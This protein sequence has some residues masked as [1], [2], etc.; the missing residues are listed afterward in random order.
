M[1]PVS[2]R[3][4]IGVV[5]S[6]GEE[7]G[8]GGGATPGAKEIPTMRSTL[9]RGFRCLAAALLFGAAFALPAKALNQLPEGFVSGVFGH[10]DVGYEPDDGPLQIVT[11]ERLDPSP[12]TQSQFVVSVATEAGLSSAA[13]VVGHVGRGFAHL[14]ALAIARQQGEGSSDADVYAAAAFSDTLTIS[15]PGLA[16]TRGTVRLGVDVEGGLSA[17]DSVLPNQPVSAYAFGGVLLHTWVDGDRSANG[18][19]FTIA[20]DLE[21]ETHVSWP[22]CCGLNG[23]E[24]IQT[25]AGFG[26]SFE[27]GTPFAFG[28]AIEIEGTANADVDAPGWSTVATFVGDF[29]GTAT[30]A[31]IFD[32]RDEAGAPVP[33]F[34]VTSLSG[35]DYRG[36]IVPEPGAALSV[37]AAVVALAWRRRGSDD[38]AERG[39]PRCPQAVESQDRAG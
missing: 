2:H 5:S 26:V 23:G 9:A 3:R 7:T 35:T 28:F 8:D 33:Q 20:T 18:T 31:G 21:R 24:T 19:A 11:D 6:N 30:W 16:G 22:A 37:Y 39:T 10:V 38:Q 29:G 12:V 34:E 32:L 1:L 27:Y 17:A 15:A 36:A 25:H 13:T 4:Q 14:D